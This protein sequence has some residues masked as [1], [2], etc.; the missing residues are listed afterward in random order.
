LRS[1]LRLFRIPNV[2]TAFADVVAGVC[3]ARDGQFGPRDLALVGASGALYLAGMVW[4]DYCDRAVDARERP[5]RPIPAGEVSPAAAAAIGVGLLATGLGLAAWH[6]HEPLVVAAALAVTI[7]LYDA[8][9]KSTAFGPLAMGT[10][11][12]LNVCLGLSVACCSVPSW[13]WLLPIALGAFTLLITRL[14]R[15]EVSGTSPQRLRSTL[16][17]FALL[18]ALIV[19]SLCWM[20]WHNQGDSLAALLTLLA[21]AF[22]GARAL[23]LLAPLAREVSPRLL[24]QAIGG[25]ILLMPALDAAFVAASGSP[26]MAAGIFALAAPAYLLKRWYYLT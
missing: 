4:N 19:Q 6:G 8:R 12:A 18:A 13:V 1:L 25:C 10:C 14:S 16:W 21:F 24:G 23:M 22:L 3:L 7:L 20:L 26:L 15:F 11:R 9:L 2:F 17:G 5:E